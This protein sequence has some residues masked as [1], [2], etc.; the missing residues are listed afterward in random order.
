MPAAE[1]MGHPFFACLGPRVCALPDSEWEGLKG[2][3]GAGLKW[4]WSRGAGLKG[5]GCGLGGGGWR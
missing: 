1:A 2:G 3:R 5:V 4:A